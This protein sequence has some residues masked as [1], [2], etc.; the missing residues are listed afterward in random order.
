MI[1]KGLIGTI[2]KARAGKPKASITDIEALAAKLEPGLGAAILKALMAQAAAV[3]LDDIAAALE[4]GDVGAVLSLLHFDGLDEVDGIT[5]RVQDAVFAGGALGATQV[6]SLSGAS[7]HFN[8]LNP[9]LI[10]WLQ[11]YSLGLIR[12]IDETTKEAIRERLVTGMRAGQNP[13]GQAVKIKQTI[14]LTIKQAKAVDN[15]RAALES[16]HLKTSAAGWNLGGK[17]DRVNQTQVWRPDDKGLPKDQVYERRLRDFRYDGKLKA[18]METGKPLSAAE[19]DK[20]VAAYHR[21][22]IALRARTIARTESL[23]TT[24]VGVQDA[25]RQAIEA[26]KVAEDRTR[27]L[28]IV[29]KDERLCESCA[30][31][32]KLNPK[33]GVAFSQPFAT[34]KGPVFLPP[35]HPNCRCTVFVRMYEPEQLTEEE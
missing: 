18:A 30:P 8:R 15:F 32:P 24:N 22:Y 5:M 20:M 17:I 3:S 31:V 10:T 9:R 23:R 11:T 4:K 1:K 12:Q 25:W 19:I 6:A 29:S 21:K 33:L 16:F 26:G 2:R 14:G 28:W 34:P 13:K 7:F 27:R 35:L